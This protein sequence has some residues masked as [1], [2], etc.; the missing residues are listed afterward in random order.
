MNY[1]LNDLK[2]REQIIIDNCIDIDVLIKMYENGIFPMAGDDDEIDFYIPD[3]RGIIPLDK[4]K[5]P[6]GLKKTLK[7]H[8]WKITL[9]NVTPEVIKECANRKQTWINKI[10]Y[11][12]YSKLAKIGKCH[13]VEIWEDK[14]LIGGLYGVSHKACF[15]GESMFSKKSQAS[16][17]ALVELVKNLKCKGFELLDTQWSTEHLK[18]FGCVDISKDKYMALLHDSLK[19]ECSFI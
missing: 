7:N 4:F 10:I 9:S 19:K 14:K 3:P 11:N 17:V 2:L 16:K 15:F 13:S 18:M 12:T 6:H 1:F 8:S 5:I